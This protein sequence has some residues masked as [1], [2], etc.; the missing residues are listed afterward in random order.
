MYTL[1]RNGDGPQQS[2]ERTVYEYL[3][4]AILSGRLPGGTPIR[5]EEIAALLGVSRIPVRDAIRHL[6][7]AGLITFESNRR[8]VVTLLKED[9]LSELFAMRAVLE[10]LAARHAVA[11]LTGDDLNRL[12]WL[13]EQ[14]DQK[15][16]T[17]DLWMPVHIEFHEFLCSRAG[18]PRLA[19]E[20]N[21]LRQRVEPY[22]R[23]QI[24]L[25]G[26]AELRLSRHG[27]VVKGIRGR[28]PERA[29]RIVRDH[30]MQ[31]SREIRATIRSSQ[32]PTERRTV[33]TGGRSAALAP[34]AVQRA[35][36]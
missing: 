20:I 5:Q 27:A 31:A 32:L 29:E 16:S 1:I 35:G 3:H 28:D 9:D 10:G 17:V 11:N 18:M 24:A 21:R 4:G 36:P 8:A 34:L 22:V 13:A 26:A 2:A 25:H 12:V 23:V 19:A 15:D 14:M 33:G 6:A 30:V 7:A